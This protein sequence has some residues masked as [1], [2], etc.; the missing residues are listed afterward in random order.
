MSKHISFLLWGV[1]PAG[2]TYNVLLLADYLSHTGYDVT[3]V[4]PRKELLSLKAI[5]M[6]IIRFLEYHFTTLFVKRT[7]LSPLILASEVPEADFYVATFW[8]TAYTVN[9][10]RAKTGMPCF[11]YIQHFEPIFYSHSYVYY[12][13]EKTYTLPLIQLTISKWLTTVISKYERGPTHVGYFIDP[14]FKPTYDHPQFIRSLKAHGKKIILGIY[15]P[16]YWKNFYLF[17]DTIT[18]LYKHRKDIYAIIIGDMTRISYAFPH[19]KIGW[20]PREDLCKYYSAA[21]VFVYTSLY[22]GFG[23]PPLEAMAC[24]CPVVM[25]DSL[26]SRDYA[27]PDVNS[28]IVQKNP[29][30]I[31]VAINELLSN[32]SLRD[33]LIREGLQTAK[34]F[35]INIAATKFEKALK[36]YG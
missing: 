25:T 29:K 21:D 17:I 13:A 4:V 7:M 36:I 16:E 28:I 18:A 26:G 20:L 9:Y 6:R 3:V 30:A 32:D 2:G 8:P 22:E 24:G 27:V 14:I 15:R 23:L 5:S 1:G 31:A 11:Y 35:S 19:K 33:S 10:L 12:L 34:S